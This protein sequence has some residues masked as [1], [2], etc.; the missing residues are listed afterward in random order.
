MWRALGVERLGGGRFRGPPP[1]SLPQGPRASPHLSGL[2][3]WVCGQ[4]GLPFGLLYEESHPLLLGGYIR[5]GKLP[6]RKR[7]RNSSTFNAPR[8]SIVRGVALQWETEAGRG[9]LGAQGQAAPRAAGCTD[10]SWGAEP[11]ARA[12][13]SRAQA[14]GSELGCR[15]AVAGGPRPGR[16]RRASAAQARR[17]GGTRSGRARG[18]AGAPTPAPPRPGASPPARPP[19]APAGEGAR[20][21]ALGWQGAPRGQAAAEAEAAPASLGRRAGGGAGRPARAAGVR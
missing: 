18:A 20:C 9:R 2:W 14:R 8:D 21:M 5:Q 1:S 3:V 16:G 19:G 11:R 12:W 17:A 10:W 15:S 7:C 6:P 4:H 13:A